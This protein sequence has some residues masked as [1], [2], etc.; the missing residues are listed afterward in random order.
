VALIA[1][2]VAA[3]QAGTNPYVITK[4]RSGRV[5]IGD[6]QFLPGY[7][8][9]LANLVVPSLNDL[10]PGAR[11]AYLRDITRVGDAILRATDAQ[12]INDE[13]L[14]N[15]EPELHAPVFPRYRSEFDERNGA[16]PV[17]RRCDREA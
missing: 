11:T 17:A 9:L 12:R 2:R 13:I 4:L 6:V 14:G 1:G 7:C 3:A 10:A 15:T 8:L 16:W 5:V